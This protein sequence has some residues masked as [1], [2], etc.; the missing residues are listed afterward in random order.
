MYGLEFLN[1]RTPELKIMFYGYLH[2]NYISVNSKTSGW[3][4]RVVKDLKGH[5]LQ[6]MT[7]NHKDRRYMHQLINECRDCK[8][9]YSKVRVVEKSTFE[10]YGI[11]L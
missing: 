7:Q 2:N 4:S 10:K 1:T 3:K 8:L 5:L 11:L 6:S 9:A